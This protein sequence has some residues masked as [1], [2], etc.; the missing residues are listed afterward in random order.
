MLMFCWWVG[1]LT[2]LEADLKWLNVTIQFDLM[3]TPLYFPIL[4]YDM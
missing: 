4:A 3:Q 1:I 2:I